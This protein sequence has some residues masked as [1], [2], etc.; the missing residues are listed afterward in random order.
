MLTAG[1]GLAAAAL[2]QI[3][4]MRDPHLLILLLAASSLEPPAPLHHMMTHRSQSQDLEGFLTHPAVSDYSHSAVSRLYDTR[5]VSQS[6]PC[7]QGPTTTTLWYSLC[8]KDPASL[9]PIRPGRLSDEL[10]AHVSTPRLAGINIHWICKYLQISANIWNCVHLSATFCDWLVIWCQ[11]LV[12]K[13][14]ILKTSPYL[15]SKRPK[16]AVKIKWYLWLNMA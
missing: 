3:L 5:G 7:L 16:Y 6:Q 9:K 4:D 8:I 15:I 1:S 13:S 2:F 14:Q 10:T 11:P 12:R